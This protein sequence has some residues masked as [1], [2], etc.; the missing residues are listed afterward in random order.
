[1]AWYLI[2]TAR[3]EAGQ[4][5][6]N[7]ILLF[8]SD[9]YPFSFTARQWWLTVQKKENPSAF[10]HRNFYSFFLHRLYGVFIAGISVT[11]YP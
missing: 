11:G 2:L 4:S 3:R 7:V 9:S 8:F 6:Q 1:M 10:Q 5:R